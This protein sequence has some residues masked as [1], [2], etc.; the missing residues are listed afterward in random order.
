MKPLLQVLIVAYGPEGIARVAEGEHPRMDGVEYVV[1]WQRGGASDEAIPSGIALRQDFRIFPSDTSGISANR[2]E[3]FRH[4]SAP[5]LLL[6]D[7]DLSYTAIHLQNVMDAFQADPDLAIAAFRY[8]SPQAPRSYPDHEFNLRQPPKGYFITSFEIAVNRERILRDD[9]EESLL[10][11]NESFGIG[12]HFCAGEEDLF[13]DR[14]LQ[15]GLKGRFFPLDVAIHPGPTTGMRRASDPEFIRTKG[16][17]VSVTHPLSWIPRMCVHALRARKTGIFPAAEYCRH[18]FAGAVEAMHPGKVAWSQRHNQW[19]WITLALIAILF[20]SISYLTPLQL[21][22]YVFMAEYRNAA[23]SER[24]SPGGLLHFWLEIRQY[25]NGRIANLLSPLTTLSPAGRIL[26]PALT[27]CAVAFIIGMT[28]ML[29]MR[30]GSRKS[31]LPVTLAWSMTLLLLPWRNSIF[32]A[33][34]ALNYV[35]GTAVT[36]LFVAVAL[37][38]DSRKRSAACAIPAILLA[39]IAGGWHEGFAFTTL[40]G[41]LLYSAYATASGKRFPLRWWITGII[42]ALSAFAFFICPGMIIRMQEQLGESPQS[43]SVFKM[44][45][46]TAPAA[47][48]LLIITAGM[49]L[50]ATRR[51][52]ISQMR[53]PLFIIMSA[54]AFTGTLLSITTQHQPRSAFWP[55]IASIICILLIFRNPLYTAVHRRY[56]R[57]PRIALTLTLTALSTAISLQIITWQKKYFDED[58]RIISLMRQSE[59]GSVFLD[60][61]PPED[62]PLQTLKIPTKSAWVTPFHYHALGEYTG[63]KFC[64][65][66]DPALAH[67]PLS[68]SIPLDSP[69]KVSLLRGCLTAPYS[70]DTRPDVRIADI[71]LTDGSVRRGV[72]APWLPY[73]NTLGDT[74]VYIRPTGIDPTCV[75]GI[76]FN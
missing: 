74:L 42:Y 49:T 22:D 17:V 27:G 52:I 64:A 6:S 69:D 73:V 57:I 53:R 7:D 13:V 72:F 68:E 9:P 41:F 1:A 67:A 19:W 34:Y 25:D 44:L 63:K 40:S 23:G 47:M 54:A 4:A 60:I 20:A 12:S 28:V 76:Y 75:S 21:D 39:I 62:L 3:A 29:T 50:R 56:L 38:L 46:D 43:L 65:V 58:R 26:F 37:R 2:N 32:V 10:R 31:A 55:D 33:D 8:V 11:F 14:I 59:S 5:L 61:I 51:R 16:A 48:L 24:L 45:A 18:W 66:V 36:L 35:W 70:P 71:R 15:A 30:S